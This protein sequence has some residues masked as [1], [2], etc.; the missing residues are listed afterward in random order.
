EA[1]PVALRELQAR[2][3]PLELVGVEEREDASPLDVSGE[4]LGRL[5]VLDHLGHGAIDDDAV[6]YHLPHPLESVARLVEADLDAIFEPLFEE[7]E[8]PLGLDAARE[9]D[10]RAARR[11]PGLDRDEELGIPHLARG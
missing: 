1:E 7:L 6:E 5:V 9:R 10:P 3:E 2:E 4:P 8:E 11:L